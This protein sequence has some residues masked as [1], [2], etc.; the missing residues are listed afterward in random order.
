MPFSN[1]LNDKSHFPLVTHT[2]TLPVSP[3]H[4]FWATLPSKCLT[5]CPFPSGFQ[6]STQVYSLGLLMINPV[7]PAILTRTQ[8][9]REYFSVIVPAFAV[10]CLLR[11]CLSYYLLRKWE[12][13]KR[14]GTFGYPPHDSW[15]SFT[16]SSSL[17]S[18]FKIPESFSS[19]T[20]QEKWCFPIVN[21][22]WLFNSTAH[23]GHCLLNFLLSS[24]SLPSVRLYLIFMASPWDVSRWENQ[25]RVVIK[26]KQ[27]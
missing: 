11:A 4:V 12:K 19:C 1:S 10:D 8:L 13:K 20:Q 16:Y 6:S 23:M 21:H 24:G 3:S 17:E 2:Y 5:T 14:E 22:Q 25:W 15:S 7:R 9:L 18:H 26:H 27:V